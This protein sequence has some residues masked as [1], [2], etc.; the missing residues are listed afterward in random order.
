VTARLRRR[1]GPVKRAGLA[2]GGIAKVVAAAASPHE[3]SH[4]AMKHGTK[5]PCHDLFANYWLT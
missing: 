2:A 4:H 1:T 5:S 3:Q